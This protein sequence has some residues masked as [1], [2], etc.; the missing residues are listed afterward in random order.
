VVDV[1]DDGIPDGWD[2]APMISRVQ[3]DVSHHNTTTATPTWEADVHPA[4]RAQV[5]TESGIHH[6]VGKTTRWALTS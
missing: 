3:V 6:A 1:D 5:G 4:N 2:S